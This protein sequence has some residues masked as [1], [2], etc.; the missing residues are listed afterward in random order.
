MPGLGRAFARR[1]APLLP[2][3]LKT[4]IAEAARGRIAP[5]GT[6][7]HSYL[8]VSL[9]LAVVDELTTGWYG[10]DWPM[11]ERAEFAFLRRLG[12]PPD[13]R[14][15]NLGAH[16]GLIAL[17]LKRLLVPTGEVIAVEMDRTNA[18]ACARNFRLNDGAGLK[19]V[20][21]AIL[22]RPGRVRA[23]RASN[24][25]ALLNGAA[26][27]WPLQAVPARTIDALVAEH[28]TPDLVYMDIEGAEVLAIRGAAQALRAVPAWYLELHGDEVCGMF[29]GRNMDVARSFAEAGF[30]LF[31]SPSE[32]APFERLAALSQLTSDSCH[33]I[34]RRQAPLGADRRG[35]QAPSA[36]A[37]TAVRSGA[38]RR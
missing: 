10:R 3:G 34:A 36:S 16:Q 37:A 15:L 12:I 29:G 8:G 23:R 11:E 25:N 5:D 1:V 19:A 2:Q 38:H 13:G 18:E 22:D 30:A 24:G 32:E 27:G 7:R 35:D 17:L 26:S 20:H 21:A 33:L 4:R 28:G 9:E 6:I 31:T 14:A